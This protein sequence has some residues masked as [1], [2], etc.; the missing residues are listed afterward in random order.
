M[1]EPIKG[2][3]PP[4]L[5]PRTILALKTLKRLKSGGDRRDVADLMGLSRE[6]VSPIFTR[7]ER[8]KL[9]ERCPTVTPGGGRTY[10]LTFRV[11][12]AGIN[13][14]ERGPTLSDR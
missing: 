9:I 13:A 10:K 7:L 1:T 12:K 6:E 2:A 8:M 14:I 4:I 3:R 11:T 5:S